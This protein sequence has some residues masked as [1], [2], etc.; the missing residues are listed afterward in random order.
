MPIVKIMCTSKLGLST[1]Y[2]TLQMLLQKFAGL[3]LILFTEQHEYLDDFVQDL[4]FRLQIHP[5]G[6]MTNLVQHGIS[7]SPGF[8]TNIGLKMV[9][10]L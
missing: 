7:I 8:Q 3:D 1:I 2:T 4:G 9:R 5:Y 6:T 10:N